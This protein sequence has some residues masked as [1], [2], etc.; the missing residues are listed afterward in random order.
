ME[1]RVF[2]PIERNAPGDFSQ[3]T[4]RVRL[5]FF[6]AYKERAYIRAEKLEPADRQL[7][8]DDVDGAGEFELKLIDPTRG[9]G[10]I[11][12]R[13]QE[14]AFRDFLGRRD[15]VCNR[16]ADAIYDHYRC[17]WGD[18]RGP[19]KPG[20]EGPYYDEILIPELSSRD[21]LKDVIRLNSVSVLDYPGIA[22]AVLGFCFSCTWDGEHG[23]GVL[24][25]DGEVIE[26]GENDL[27]WR[28]PPSA[29]EYRPKPATKRQIPMQ[30]GVAAVKKLG[31]KV[32]CES[33]DVE[34]D[35]L[36]NERVDDADLASLKPFPEM[37]QLRVASPRITDA[38]LEVL[39]G[40]KDLRL[41]ELSGARI[42][43]AGLTRLHGLKHLKTLYL[44]GTQITDAGLKELR[45]LP[46]LAG[47]R[48]NETDVTDVG[49]KEIGALVGLK[50]LELSGCRIT[51]DGIQELK[52]LQSLITLDL[53]STQVTDAGLAVLK[54]CKSLRYLNLSRCRVTDL[55][56]EPLKELNTLRTLKLASTATTEAGVAGLQRVL[57]GLQVTR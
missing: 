44:G 7:P 32:R 42:T 25:R 17:H 57:P 11:P 30:Y 56:L 1:H 19:A 2:G 20:A 49:L 4:G 27:T 31:G 28:G 38:G 10:H 41:L 35:L 53:Q 26:I 46:A 8:P 50:H 37:H 45:Q 29:G 13:R 40:F 22:M 39:R 55:G 24:V 9:W 34:V 21:G 48:L 5:D 51:D 12:S 18:W 33:G 23:L 43:D 47:L 14:E 3:W 15:E 36:R 6:S 52:G 54:G 16:V